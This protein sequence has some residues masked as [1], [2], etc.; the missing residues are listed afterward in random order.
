MLSVRSHKTVRH[1]RSFQQKR[2]I[3]GGNNA[4][5]VYENRSNIG[6]DNA[7]S[8]PQISVSSFFNPVQKREGLH[9]KGDHH[10]ADAGTGRRHQKTVKIAD[11]SPVR[12]VFKRNA[13]KNADPP[14]GGGQHP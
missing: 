8:E 12:E 13:A 5:A 3:Y 10:K 7:K 4:D 2:Q 14:Y 6:K 11:V 9:Q 1:A